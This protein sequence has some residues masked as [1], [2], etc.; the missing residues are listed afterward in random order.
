MAHFSAPSCEV[1][2]SEHPYPWEQHV[3]KTPDGC[4]VCREDF[5]GPR[6]G[7]PIRPGLRYAEGAYE[8][9]VPASTKNI[10]TREPGELAAYGPWFTNFRASLNIESHGN[11]DSGGGLIFRLNEHGCYL[12]LVQGRGYTIAYKLAKKFWGGP[13]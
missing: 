6:S 10:G 1:S 12:L 8:I 4:T 13:G 9:S 2:A 11:P 7:W 3:A 5:S